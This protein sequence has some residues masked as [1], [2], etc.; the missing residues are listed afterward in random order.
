[1]ILADAG[2]AVVLACVVAYY[3]E[4]MGRSAGGRGFRRVAALGLVMALLYGIMVGS[5]FGLS[6]APDSLLGRLKILDI[7]DIDFMMQMSIIIGC[8]HLSLAN[9]VVAYRAGDFSAKLQPLGW[10]AAIFGGLFLWLKPASS[11]GTVLLLGGLA[12]VAIFASNRKIDS[13]KSALLRLL[14]GLKALSGVSGMFGD[15]LS[16]LRLFALGLSS[17]SLAITFNQLAEQVREGLP[18][19]G[20]LLSILVLIL[21]H[22]INLG[23]GIISGFVHGLRLNF[24]EFF[25]WG[26]AEEGHLFQ[27]FAKKEVKHE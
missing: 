14:D 6:P 17:A 12:A 11:I 23:L 13:L 21:G 4:R 20:L 19:L 3:W 10:I 1:M 5:F 9:A 16:Y 7:N 2:Y 15:I 25:K 18:G 22:G 24:L 27:P 26:I 8:L